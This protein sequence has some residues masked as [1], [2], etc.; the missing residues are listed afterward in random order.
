MN[1]I[2]T[3]LFLSFSCIS[4]MQEDENGTHAAQQ[5]ITFLQDYLQIQQQLNQMSQRYS[6]PNN[7]YNL[8]G[9]HRYILYQIRQEQHSTPEKNNF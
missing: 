4:A 6:D 1:K 8:I 5:Q 2:V 7:S 9:L 3:S